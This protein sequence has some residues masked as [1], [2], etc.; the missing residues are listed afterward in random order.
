MTSAVNQ[1]TISWGRSA[2]SAQANVER[3]ADTAANRQK[4]QAEE[5]AAKLPSAVIK[6]GNDILLISGAALQTA[7]RIARTQG[8]SINVGDALTVNG[9]QGT[10]LSEDD[11]FKNV[12]TQG[13]IVAVIDTGLDINHPALQ[14]RI[15]SPY[16]AINGT[17]NVTDEEGHG[18]HVAGI[19]AGAWGQNAEAG[20]VDPNCKIMPIKAARSNGGFRASDVANGIRYAADHGAKVINMSLGGPMWMPY[21]QD[22]IAYAESKGVV[23]VAAMG[24]SGRNKPTFPAKFDGVIAVGS[25]KDG[26]RSAFSNFGD[27]LDVSAPGEKIVSTMP[28][29][30]YGTKS[31][32]SMASPY[33]AGEA[34]LIIA[35]HPDWSAAQVK[36]QVER[37]VN[38]MSKDGWDANFGYGEANLFKAV[39]GNDL[40]AVN[41]TTKPAAPTFWQKILAFF[42]R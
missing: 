26:K 25:S 17:D 19:I 7:S 36:A 6:Q 2:R 3:L 18:T 42:G 1:A 27:R 34:A 9:L 13:I 23:V 38:V 5:A 31:G 32:T 24:N 21:V 14:G 33:V 41:R 40:A 10:V 35:A 29:G 4:L 28:G 12:D 39:Y 30:K 37:A 15:V 8:D 16:N 11:G 22:A 20:G